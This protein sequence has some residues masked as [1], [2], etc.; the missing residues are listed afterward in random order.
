M[1][2]ILSHKITS[3]IL[4]IFV[5]L[6][7]VAVST[8][9]YVSRR[10]QYP[11]RE[12]EREHITKTD[13][14]YASLHS[15]FKMDIRSSDRVSIVRLMDDIRVHSPAHNHPP[16]ERVKDISHFEGDILSI[17][18]HNG[19]SI[20]L[21]LMGPEKYFG[22]TVYLV[23]IDN[24]PYHVDEWMGLYIRNLLSPYRKQMN[25]TMKTEE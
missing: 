22:Q 1:K 8:F 4:L 23:Y 19:D 14:Q 17:N 20:F 24:I 16:L 12:F 11:V 10:E 6:E 18:A 21:V 13:Y 2:K 5:V 15:D 3:I 7:C 25:K 9:F